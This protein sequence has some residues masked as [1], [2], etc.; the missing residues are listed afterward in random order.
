MSQEQETQE[1]PGRAWWQWWAPLAMI[2]VFL[3]L[4]P[5]IYQA[6]SG[7]VLLGL[8][9]GLTVLIAFIDAATFRYSWTIFW[10][11]GIAYF[12]AMAM[13]FNEGTWIYL[14]VVVLLAWSASKL[15]AKVRKR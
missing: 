14:P 11:A 7:T 1:E 3:V 15:G 4:P 6:V 8:M 10:V 5:A 9:G 2:A 12:A 13:Y